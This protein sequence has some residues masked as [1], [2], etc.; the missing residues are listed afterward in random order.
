MLKRKISYLCIAILVLAIVGAS[1][2]YVFLK[3][4]RK[5]ETITPN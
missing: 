5:I 4:N 1:V 3:S 2:G